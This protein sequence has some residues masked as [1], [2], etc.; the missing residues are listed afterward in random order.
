[1]NIPKFES[2]KLDDRGKIIPHDM[3]EEAKRL[4]NEFRAKPAHIHTNQVGK[5]INYPATGGF[6]PETCTQRDLINIITMRG[7][8]SMSKL[9]SAYRYLAVRFPVE[10]AIR[11]KNAPAHLKLELELIESEAKNDIAWFGQVGFQNMVRLD[12]SLTIKNTKIMKK[13]NDRVSF[14]TFDKSRRKILKG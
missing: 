5:K 13:P 4:A 10:F 9:M 14:F 2:I 12:G 11:K 3:I 6:D 8:I 7:K 1:M